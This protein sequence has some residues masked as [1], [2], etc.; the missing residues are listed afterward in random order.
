MAFHLGSLGFLT[1]FNFDTYQSQVNQVIEGKAL[2]LFFHSLYLF[3][4]QTL[5]LGSRLSKGSEIL[6]FPIWFF[7]NL[8]TSAAVL[9]FNVSIYRN[10][11]ALVSQ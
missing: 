1:P 8:Y 4:L 9:C 10:A 3:I 2:H 7:N 6:D 11:I 5:F